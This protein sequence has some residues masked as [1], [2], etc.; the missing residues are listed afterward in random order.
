[1]PDGTSQV[2]PRRALL[3]W[4]GGKWLLAPWIIAHFPPHRTYVEPFGGAASVLLR[5]PRSHAEIY[6]DLEDG[7]VGLFRILREPDAAEELKRRLELTPFARTEFQDA[8]LTTNDPLEAARRL[9]IRCFMG[10]GSD[11]AR[12]DKTTGFRANSNRSGTTPAH[13]WAS[14]PAALQLLVQRLRGVV[15]EQRDAL[16]CMAT[17]DGQRTLHYVDPPYMPATRRLSHR[18]HGYVHEMTEADHEHLLFEM[19]HLEG[20]IVLSGYRNEMYDA[21][22][23][24]WRRVDR[25]TFADGASPRRESIWMNPV[26]QAG[27][28]QPDLL[29]EQPHA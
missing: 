2:D 20:A 17:H 9:I 7:V 8:F 25:E 4:H 11:G 16:A 12:I 21:M 28:R 5:K 24:G 29:A 3:R 14:Y 22:L 27:L 6:N 18:G 19:A 1:M 15:I 26:A 10:F 23:S 13:D